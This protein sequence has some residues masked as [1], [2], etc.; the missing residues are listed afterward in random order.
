MIELSPLAL[1]LTLDMICL[2]VCVG[3]GIAYAKTDRTNGYLTA[4][5]STFLLFYVYLAFSILS[6]VV[7]KL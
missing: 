5:F 4:V 6:H 1:V 2:G 3:M 7:G